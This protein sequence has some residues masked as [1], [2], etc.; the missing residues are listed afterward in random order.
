MKNL[1]HVNQE[2]ACFCYQLNGSYSLRV[3]PNLRWKMKSNGANFVIGLERLTKC[4]CIQA[5][6]FPFGG[7]VRPKSVLDVALATPAAILTFRLAEQ[8]NARF[9][10]DNSF[11]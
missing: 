11:C 10:C 5:A 9:L 1:S 2:K 8:K 6:Y 7:V 4:L 3:I